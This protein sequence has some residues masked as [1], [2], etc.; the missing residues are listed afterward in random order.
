MDRCVGLEGLSVTLFFTGRAYNLLVLTVWTLMESQLQ[1][2]AA[3]LKVGELQQ[4]E[5]GEELALWITGP[6]LKT[7]LRNVTFVSLVK[8]S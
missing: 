8:S 3:P 7:N 4:L 1:R 6:F 2:S 5:P